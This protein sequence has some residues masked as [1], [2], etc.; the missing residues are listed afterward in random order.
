M[1]YKSETEFAAVI[2]NEFQGRFGSYTTSYW[3]QKAEDRKVAVNKYLWNENKG[4]YFDYNIKNNSQSNFIG[5]STLAPLWANMCSMDQAEKLVKSALP[6]LIETGG[7]AGS[8]KDSR[9]DITP[10]RPARQ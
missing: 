3:Q 9:G 1:L 10:E 2:E 6:L 5:A 7:I 4:L 8:T